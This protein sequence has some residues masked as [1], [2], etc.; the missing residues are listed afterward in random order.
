MFGF[1]Y[2]L[3]DR[4]TLDLAVLFYVEDVVQ[5]RA[6]IK[7]VPN[8]FIRLRALLLHIVENDL[9]HAIVVIGATCRR[10][11]LLFLLLLDLLK[12]II[13]QSMRQVI[14]VREVEAFTDLHLLKQVD[15][16]H[17]VLFLR[18]ALEQGDHFHV[19]DLVDGVVADLCDLGSFGDHQQIVAFE[20]ANEAKNTVSL[21]DL[22]V[23]VLVLGH[24]SEVEGAHRLVRMRAKCLILPIMN[25][26][27]ASFCKVLLHELL[28]EF[29]VLH[30]RH[31]LLVLGLR[32]R[33][34]L[35]FDDRVEFEQRTILIIL[36][37]DSDDVVLLSMLVSCDDHDLLVGLKHF[38]VPQIL[39][40][41]Q[42]VYCR[43]HLCY[44]LSLIQILL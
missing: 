15:I 17:F 6:I 3:F 44:S 7:F 13:L 8:I 25:A 2:L 18:S 21:L 14:S 29:L 27:L 16:A 10:L 1:V 36:L 43:I 24:A 12:H 41:W 9:W 39:L 33:H 38:E 31:I 11:A 40:Q 30:A 4:V 20:E 19:L 32:K 37:V 42:H 22:D 34:D 5:V 35:F 23:E 28:I 26:H